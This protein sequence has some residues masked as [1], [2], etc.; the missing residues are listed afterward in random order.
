[1]ATRGRLTSQP[2]PG[3]PCVVKALL[4][5]RGPATPHASCGT[6]C[7]CM[8]RLNACRGS[9]PPPR[10]A[11]TLLLVVSAQVFSLLPLCPTPPSRVPR[12]AAWVTCQPT[13][14]C[15]ACR[16]PMLLPVVLLRGRWSSL[17]VPSA[18]GP[19]LG[20]RL[21]QTRGECGFYS[22][23]A[24]VTRPQPAHPHM[25]T[26]NHTC[27]NAIHVRCTCPRVGVQLCVCCTRCPL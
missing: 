9:L 22:S 26:V 6:R 25:P 17:R 2:P 19:C 24:P 8:V 11:R 12:Q 16:C 15:T 3:D 14:T 5:P 21:W 7:L 18:L 10:P 1:M 27:T 23:C 20:T 13:G 4:H